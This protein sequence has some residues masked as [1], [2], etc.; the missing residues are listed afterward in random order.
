MSVPPE[1][2]SHPY[3]ERRPRVVVA[4]GGVAALEACLALRAA[5]SDA[6]VEIELIAPEERF[7]Y[8][9]LAVLEPFTEGSSWGLELA[10]FAHDQ[11]VVLRRDGLES[12]D[13]AR[14]VVHTTSGA[15]VP[16][17][18]LLVALGARTVRHVAGAI[19]FRGA[20]DAAALRRI[21]DATI[22]GEVRALAFALPGHEFWSLP[23]YELAL[24]TAARLAAE[25]V[26][27]GRVRIL[28]VT[29]ERAPLEL[30]GARASR[31]V[32][33]LLERHGIEL[34]T[35]SVPLRM[36]GDG[37]ELA[38]G[39]R[40]EVD[41]AVVLPRLVGRPIEGLPHDEADFLPTDEHA[42]V[43]DCPGVFA[44][45]D[46]TSS[47]WKQGGL[48]TQQADAAAESILADLGL[49][50]VPRPYRPVLQGVLYTDHDPEY[51]QAPLGD[52]PGEE[53][54]PRTYSLWW[55]PSKIAGRYLA[56]YLTLRAGA[57]RAP[58][59]RPEADLVPVEV[60]VERVHATM[61]VVGGRGGAPTVP[62][63]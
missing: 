31:L 60:D 29:P 34:V 56:P 43:A 57:P 48:A 39:R 4:G 16:Y 38:D 20:Q 19:T 3:D 23:I 17:D 10:R 49:P 58:E 26:G 24:M 1:A 42:R 25:G 45:G 63:G 22:A 35:E 14:R 15:E 41:A 5:V 36:E 27:P 61:P 12:V 62:P 50:I 30:F 11:D 46:V 47:P 33:G 6:D 9:P 59:V 52:S 40:L 54:A 13:A 32:A 51:L 28:L 44:A 21:V 18:H 8:R 53:L 37:L 7:Q 55:P 2:P